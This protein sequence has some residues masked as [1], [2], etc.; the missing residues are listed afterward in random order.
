MNNLFKKASGLFLTEE[1]SHEEYMN[2]VDSGGHLPVS[3]NYEYWDEL[4]LEDAIIGVADLLE[5][6]A[7][8]KGR[9][10]N[11]KKAK[12]LVMNETSTS[13]H[14]E[15]KL[16]KEVIKNLDALILINKLCKLK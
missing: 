1:M 9:V 15:M 7:A 14:G 4:Q 8:N 6:E 11:L 3:E 2:I 16:S 12:L 13:S 10:R 5:R